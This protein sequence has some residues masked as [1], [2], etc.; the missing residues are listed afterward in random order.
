MKICIPH[1]LSTHP[2]VDLNTNGPLGHVPDQAGLSVVPLVGH[3]LRHEKDNMRV[4]TS[5]REGAMSPQLFGAFLPRRRQTLWM[6][7]FT[8]MSM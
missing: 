6:A 2:L 3:T 5:T 8:L 1:L 7:E 4:R